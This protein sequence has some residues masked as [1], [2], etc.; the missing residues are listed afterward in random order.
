MTA[1]ELILTE[2]LRISVVGP[3]VPVETWPRLLTDQH[4]GLNGGRK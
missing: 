4:R 3:E 1:D 2:V